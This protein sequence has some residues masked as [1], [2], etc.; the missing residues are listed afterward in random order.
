LQGGVPRFYHNNSG[1]AVHLLINNNAIDN[2]YEKSD[3][4]NAYL[5]YLKYNLNSH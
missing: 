1:E 4:Y 2:N 5:D 3:E